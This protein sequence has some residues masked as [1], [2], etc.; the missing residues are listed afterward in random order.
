MN[1]ASVSKDF[2]ILKSKLKTIW[3]TGDYDLFC[4][5]M[6]P[7][8]EDFYQRLNIP[9]GAR[10]LDVACGSGQLSLVAARH[11]AVVTGID[12]ADNSIE[13]ARRNA[14]AA[15]LRIEFEQGDA[16]AL[17]YL[18]ATFDAVVSTIG[19]MFAPVPEAVAA[20]M[21]RVCRPGGTVA[22]ANW[23]PEGFVGK[24]FRIIAGYIAPSGMPSPLLWGKESVVTERLQPELHD[25]QFSRHHYVL[26]YPLTPGEVVD[27]FRNYYG[28][29]N[30]AFRELDLRGKI[31]LHDEL[32][33]LWAQHNESTNG[34]TR[35]A[36]EYLQ[37]VARRPT[38]S[39]L[40]LVS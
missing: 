18:D 26:E 33:A 34:T 28:P 19:A 17:P 27:F 31:A 6:Q 40:I 2:E 14:L 25:I 29:M 9:A 4:R 5:P 15:G 7:N 24:M 22:M 30:C 16:E 37:V 38:Y 3:T 39:K 12:I 36:A 1:C 10:V 32:E 20:E 21:T 23:T 11:G 35:V 8:A 13:A